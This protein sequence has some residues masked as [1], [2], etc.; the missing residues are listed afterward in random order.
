[1][2]ICWICSHLNWN[3]N[4]F[5]VTISLSLRSYDLKADTSTNITALRTMELVPEKGLEPATLG[6]L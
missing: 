3:H 4:I 5:S 2:P 1:M 6:S